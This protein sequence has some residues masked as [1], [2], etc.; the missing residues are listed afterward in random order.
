MLSRSIYH[1][2]IQGCNSVHS[3]H[4][5]QPDYSLHSKIDSTPA[6]LFALE[7]RLSGWRKRPRGGEDDSLPSA[8]PFASP[9]MNKKSA[10]LFI[11]L[12]TSKH[13]RS[14]PDCK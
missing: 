6:R 3:V 2:D 4:L 7:M 11:L 14:T 1:S 5:F 10:V 8:C 13:Y 9:L 12:S